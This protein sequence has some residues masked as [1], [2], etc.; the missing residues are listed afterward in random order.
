MNGG[1]Q[2]IVTTAGKRGRGKGGEVQITVKHLQKV[3]KNVYT[4]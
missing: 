2:V 1:G 4:F 3:P